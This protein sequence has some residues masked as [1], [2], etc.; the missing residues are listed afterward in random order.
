MQ[1]TVT[2]HLPGV[3]VVPTFQ[4]QLTEPAASAV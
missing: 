2:G 4:V 3:V 1:V